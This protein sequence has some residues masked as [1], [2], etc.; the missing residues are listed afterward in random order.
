MSKAFFFFFFFSLL[1]PSG[2]EAISEE[3]LLDNQ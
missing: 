1:L 2:Q 3:Q